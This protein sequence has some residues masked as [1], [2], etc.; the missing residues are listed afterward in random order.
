MRR[1]LVGGEVSV[2][3]LTLETASYNAMMKNQGIPHEIEP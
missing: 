3:L 1:S 2:L